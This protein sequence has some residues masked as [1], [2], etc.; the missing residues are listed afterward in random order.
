VLLSREEGGG[1]EAVGPTSRPSTGRQQ[2]DSDAPA[3]LE[4]KATFARF[5]PH[6]WQ[7]WVAFWPCAP[8]GGTARGR[9]VGEHAEGEALDRHRPRARAARCGEVT[10]MPPRQRRSRTSSRPIGRSSPANV[11]SECRVRREART[12][13]PP[14]PGVVVGRTLERYRIAWTDGGSSRRRRGAAK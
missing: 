4:H 10:A 1:H 3:D 5:K 2:A 11:S 12:D 13:R 8:Y 7:E 6:Q 9:R 14:C